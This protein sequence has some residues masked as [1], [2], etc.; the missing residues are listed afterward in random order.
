MN[1]LSETLSNGIRIL[2]VPESSSVSYMGFAVN[3]GTRDEHISEQGSSYFV[4]HMLFKGTEHRK[5]WH[6]IDRLESVGGQMDAYTT[7]EETF[8]YT[9]I[10]DQH[11]DR[12]MELLSDIMFHSTFPQTEL[13]REREVVLDEIQSYNDSPSELIYDEF[14]ELLFAGSSIGRNILGKEEFLNTFDTAAM[15]RF[16]K[17]CYTTDQILFFYSGATPFSKIQKYAERYFTVSGSSREYVRP[18]IDAYKPVMR[19]EKKETYQT[20]CI[21]GNRSYGLGHPERLALVLLN[22]ILGG[23]FMSSRLNHSIRE[24][25]GLAYTIE[26]G[27][28]TYTDSGV[29]NIYFGCDPKNVNRCLTLIEREL[30]SLRDTTMN[31]TQLKR[32]KRQVEGQLLIGNQNKEVNTTV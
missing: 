27:L 14:E 5:S 2:Y 7:K 9:T 28:T 6:I 15:Q 3:A 13:E 21:L 24:R 18:G 12:A 30:D 8:V 19:E 16:V 10:P 1:Y 29:W 22:N 26:S 32:A 20:H 17:R 4:E 11:T 23:P 25:N 31:E